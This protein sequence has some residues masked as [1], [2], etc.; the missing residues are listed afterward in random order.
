MSTTTDLTIAAGTVFADARRGELPDPVGVAAAAHS[1]GGAVQI[2]L[3]TL[4]DLAQWAQW[5]ETTIETS[6]PKHWD[7]EKW[8][9]HHTAEGHIHEL[10]VMLVAVEIGVM[11]PAEHYDCPRCGGSIGTSAGFVVMGEYD[12]AFELEVARHQTGECTPLAVAP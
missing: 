5:A 3:S 4:A 11:V 2:H 12:D 1:P 10:P 8:T 7:G 6:D 9:R